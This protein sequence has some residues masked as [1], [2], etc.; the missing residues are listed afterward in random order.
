VS[1]LTKHLQ[2]I[3]ISKIVIPEQRA[4]SQFT[5][6]QLAFLRGSLMKYGVLSYPIVRPKPDGTYELIDGEHRLKT[7]KEMGVEEIEC[8]VIPANDKD[9]AI[10]NILMNVAR[11]TSNPMDIAWAIDKALKAGMSYEEIARVFN[12]SESWV[13]FYHGLLDLPEEYQE[14]LRQ[15]KLTPTHIREALRLPD[16]NEI[17]AAL[18]TAIRLGWSASVLKN[19]VDNRLEQLRE[20]QAKLEAGLVEGPPPPPEPEKLVRFSQCLVCGR[21][22]ERE[23]IYLPAVCEDCYSL[24]KYVVEQVGT[25][26]DA[27]NLIF[28]AL[29]HYQQFRAFQQQYFMYQQFQQYQQSQM[30]GQQQ[31]NAGPVPQQPQPGPS[32]MQPIPYAPAPVGWTTP[33]PAQQQSMPQ[34]LKEKPKEQQEQP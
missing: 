29:R 17:R 16:L 3:P 19:Y 15:G 2:K 31:Q 24:S 4:R 13:K 25:G 1:E 18:D 33:P 23:K 30:Q 12:R 6:E 22:V 9:A 20:H 14:A 32:S 28:E 21:M 27:M 5:E 34:Q 26:Q 10:I 11:G 7:A 8:V